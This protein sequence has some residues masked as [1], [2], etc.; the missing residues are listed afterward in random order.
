MELAII[1]DDPVEHLILRELATAIRPG[2]EVSGFVSIEHFLDANPDRFDLVFLDRRLPPIETYSESL[3]LIS[4]AGYTGHIV[5]MT[6]DNSEVQDDR[7][8]FRLS[9]PIDKIE[10]IRGQKL[11]ALLAA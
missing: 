2:V 11:A 10:L 3:P 7:Y 8:T 9:G 5:L 6:A 1:D 4:E